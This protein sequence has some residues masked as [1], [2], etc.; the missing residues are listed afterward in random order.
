MPEVADWIG[1]LVGKFGISR[2][3]LIYNNTIYNNRVGPGGGECLILDGTDAAV[4]KNNICYQNTVDEITLVSVDGNPTNTG[5]A[6]SNNLLGVDPQ[7]R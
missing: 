1:I 6:L 2:R 7:F 3:N 4:V 5:A